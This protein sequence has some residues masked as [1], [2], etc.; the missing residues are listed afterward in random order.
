MFILENI[1]ISKNLR[2]KTVQIWK[3]RIYKKIKFE[4]VQTFVKN[5][6]LKNKISKKYPENKKKKENVK[7]R[8]N[9]TR[10]KKHKQKMK[11]KWKEEG[12]W[13]KTQPKWAGPFVDWCGRDGVPTRWR[14]DIVLAEYYDEVRVFTL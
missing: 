8:E 11:L 1:H 3:S 2:L 5:I 14:R 6:V 12:K 4:K 7:H 9:R 10:N 13:E